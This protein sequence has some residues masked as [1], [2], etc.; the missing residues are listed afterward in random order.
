MNLIK[1]KTGTRVKTI[2]QHT[3]NYEETLAENK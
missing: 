1:Y 2:H 3:K